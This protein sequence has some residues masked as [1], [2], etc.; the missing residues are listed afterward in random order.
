[1]NEWDLMEALGGIEEELLLTPKPRKP[2]RWRGGLR[3]ALVAAVIAVLAGTVLA[4]GL[5]VGVSYGKK[6][7]TLEGVSLSQSPQEGQ[8]L[9]YYTAQIQ[10]DMHIAELKDPA[11]FTEALTEA[12]ERNGGETLYDLKEADGSLLNLGSAAAAEEL[13]GIDLMDS[14][15]LTALVRGVYVT[16]LVC[17]PQSAAEAY[18]AEGQ[19]SPDGL[20]LYLSLRRGELSTQALDAHLVSESGITVFVPLTENFVRMQGLQTLYSHENQGSF[21]QSGLMTQEGKSLLLLENSSTDLGQTGYAAWCDNGLGY[22]AHLKTY[23]KGYATPLSLLVP[24]LQ[25]IR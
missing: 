7:V 1:M 23:P 24:L 8:T 25:R 21:A 2:L 5:G 22:L 18:A 13:L 4:V 17:T 12:W 3:I 11:L 20:I 9:S 14:P 16:M 6:T 19:I 15:E 10:Y